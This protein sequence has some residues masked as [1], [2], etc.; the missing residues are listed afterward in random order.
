MQCTCISAYTYERC[1]T[2]WAGA[3]TGWGQVGCQV[4]IHTHCPI[5]LTS[6]HSP[7]VSS[8]ELSLL[9]T[10]R[11]FSPATQSFC[12]LLFTSRDKSCIGVNL[13]SFLSIFHPVPFLCP[14][15]DEHPFGNSSVLQSYSLKDTHTLSG[16][17]VCERMKEY[18]PQR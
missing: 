3:G 2:Q 10:W 4:S 17:F 14:D 15:L 16:A 9:E 8:L 12:F 6:G 5:S 13:S 11:F 7:R 1:A 18:N